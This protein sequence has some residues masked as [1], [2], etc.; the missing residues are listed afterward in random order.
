MDGVPVRPN[1]FLVLSN[2][3]HE[4]RILDRAIRFASAD[5]NCLVQDDDRIPR[6]P[7]WLNSALEL[8]EKHPKLAIWAGSWDFTASIRILEGCGASGKRS[9]QFVDHVNIGP[10]FI[11]REHYLQMGGFDLSYSRAGEPGIC[12]DNELCLRAWVNGYQVGNSFVP[13]KGPAAS[14]SLDGGTTRFS[15]RGPAQKST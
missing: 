2:D 1:D 8:F 11:R 3:L 9:F 7:S 5:V 14:Y 10:Y 4:I 12:F 6:G 13:F 15:A